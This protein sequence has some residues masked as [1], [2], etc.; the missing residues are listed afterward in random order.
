MQEKP[1]IFAEKAR[2]ET[3]FLGRLII[4]VQNVFL[5]DDYFDRLFWEGPFP[6]KEIANANCFHQ[7]HNND[8]LR[9]KSEFVSTL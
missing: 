4:K 9:K 8:Q 5:L 2:F 3:R 6:E 7:K 1:E